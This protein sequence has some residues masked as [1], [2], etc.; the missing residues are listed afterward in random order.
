MTCRYP[1]LRYID[2]QWSICVKRARACARAQTDLLRNSKNRLWAL[3]NKKK[4]T[5]TR[6][7]SFARTLVVCLFRLIHS[8]STGFPQLQLIMVCTS[9]NSKYYDVLRAHFSFSSSSCN[10]HS[11]ST[12]LNRCTSRPASIAN[13]LG[14]PVKIRIWPDL[15]I[16]WQIGTIYTNCHWVHTPWISQTSLTTTT[17]STALRLSTWSIK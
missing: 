14:V 15:S 11:R 5:T 8:Q 16:C 9:F 12:R 4:T 1:Y 6:L 13:A 17:A 3:A 2:R 10:L 7:A